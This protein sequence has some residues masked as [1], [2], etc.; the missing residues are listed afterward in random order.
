MCIFDRKSFFILIVLNLI[1]L[2]PILSY[3]DKSDKDG[4]CKIFFLSSNGQNIFV[5]PY[6]T[7]LDSNIK[8]KFNEKQKSFYNISQEFVQIIGIQYL[9][10]VFSRLSPE[11][12]TTIVIAM[13]GAEHL[14]T[15]IEIFLS[16][17]P[18]LKKRVD[19]K[20]VPLQTDII[21]PWY[22][23]NTQ[24]SNHWMNRSGIG[25][26]PKGFSFNG[27]R[28]ADPSSFIEYIERQRLLKH[29]K[30]LV[31]DTG[32]KGTTVEAVA[33]SVRS[34]GYKG[35]V[36]GVLV[37]HNKSHTENSVPIFALNSTYGIDRKIATHW[38]VVLDHNNTDGVQDP[39]NLDAFQRSYYTQIF[40]REETLR[41]RKISLSSREE[42][43]NYHA[44]LFGLYDAL[45]NYW[46]E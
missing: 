41:V 45:E 18:D 5:G 1:F 39:S 31:L 2:N 22:A 11:G 13:G 36:E 24:N 35:N 25:P 10:L 32:F 14:G 28:R 21:R 38:A 33:Y 43:L 19:I 8:N 37:S 9:K 27:G 26:L 23:I 42:S 12:K 46:S 3:A 30:I 4:S 7:H 40:F 15:L 34:L 6:R 20:Y 44:T 29:N 17:R 16:R